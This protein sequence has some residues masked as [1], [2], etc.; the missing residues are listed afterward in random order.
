MKM[1]SNASS[2]NYFDFNKLNRKWDRINMA[3]DDVIKEYNTTFGKGL[4]FGKKNIK[5]LVDEYLE[6]DKKPIAYKK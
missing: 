4:K 1:D 5:N 3:K 6:K 2:W